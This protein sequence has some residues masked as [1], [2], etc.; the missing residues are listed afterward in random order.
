[1]STE[2]KGKIT[3]TNSKPFNNNCWEQPKQP[4]IG[5]SQRKARLPQVLDIIRCNGHYL[6]DNE[7]G[8]DQRNTVGAGE[9]KMVLPIVRCNSCEISCDNGLLRDSLEKRVGCEPINIRPKK[10]VMLM[11][12]TCVACQR[13]A[14]TLL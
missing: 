5:Q 3:L 1:M 10:F 6:R 9:M 4:A 12:D 14:I 7:Q 13:E 2:N 11:A 8:R